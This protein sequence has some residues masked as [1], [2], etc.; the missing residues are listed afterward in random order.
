CRAILSC[1]TAAQRLEDRMRAEGVT[2]EAFVA[3]SAGIRRVPG[4]AVFMARDAVA[5]PAALLH[6]LKH[7][8][9]LAEQEVLA[10]VSSLDVPYVAEAERVTAEDLGEGFYRII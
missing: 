3:M 7:N 2:F 8:M 9:V 10:P 1:G 6:H 4:M 5:P